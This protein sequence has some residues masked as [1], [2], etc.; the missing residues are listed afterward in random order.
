M[1][2]KRVEN[3]YEV[4]F[5]AVIITFS[6]CIVTTNEIVELKEELTLLKSE[7]TTLK[8]NQAELNSKMDLLN[9]NLGVYTEKLEEN[10]YKM[11]I[12][13]QRMDDIHSSITQRMDILSKQL[14]KVDTTILPLP[15]E[16]FQIAY[17]DYNKG[18]YDLSVRGFK[19]FLEKYPDSELAPKAYYYLSDA[20]FVKKQFNEAVNVIDEYVS[21]YNKDDLMPTMLYKKSQ[22]FISLSLPKQAKEIQDYILKNYPNSKEAQSIKSVQ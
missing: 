17:N 16:M 20:Y 5:L 9:T 3:F 10:K 8:R 14:P 22:C 7:I 15:T 2:K 21:K 18:L 11:S 1:M 12:L 6:G 19:D 13:A 4:L